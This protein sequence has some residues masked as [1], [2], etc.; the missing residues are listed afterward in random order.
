MSPREASN[1]PKPGILTY[2]NVQGYMYAILL[3]NNQETGVENSV[4]GA[5][6]YTLA[7]NDFVHG[8]VPNV[9]D[10][11][12]NPIPIVK[13]GDPTNSNFI[14]ALQGAGPLFG[15]AGPF[16][17]MPANGPPFFTQ[18]QIQPIIDWVTAGCPD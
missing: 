17:Q 12:G 16:G 10:N 8:N 3:T 15:P 7:Y 6:W 2:Q 18:Q 14:L 11:S 4:H 9:T 5:Y 13:P 1:P